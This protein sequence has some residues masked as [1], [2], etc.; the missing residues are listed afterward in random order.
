MSTLDIKNNDFMQGNYV[1]A[2][3]T[4]APDAVIIN[5]GSMSATRNGYVVLSGDYVENDGRIQAQTGRV[6]LA[7]GANATLTF[8]SHNLISYT[9][10]GATLARLAGAVNAGDIVATGGTVVM[11][12]DV[13]NA[14][15][16]TAVNNQGFIAAKSIKDHG[17]T[18]VLEATGGELINSGTLFANAAAGT[19]NMGGGTIILRGDDHT[20]L[21]STSRIDAAGDGTGAGG[22]IELS[23]HTLGVKGAA[24]AGKGGHLLIDPS[25]INITSGSTNGAGTGPTNSVGIGFIKNALN[26]N[27]NVT[28]VASNSIHNVTSGKTLTATG[29]GNLDFETGTVTC[30]TG[31]CVGGTPTITQ[32]TGTIDLRGLT[33]NIAGN[34]TAH[35]GFGSGNNGTVKLSDV[36]AKGIA[37]TG[38]FIN[39]G[40][41]H[42]TGTPGINLHAVGSSDDGGSLAA[43]SLTADTGAVSI[44]QVG[45]RTGI[46]VGAITANQGVFIS[47]GSGNQLLNVIIGGNVTGKS[48]TIRANGGN[49]D[50]IGNV[51]ATNGSVS[52]SARTSGS[53]SGGN[54]D[55]TGTITAVGARGGVFLNAFGGGSNATGSGGGNITVGGAIAAGGSVGISASYKQSGHAFKVQTSGITAGNTGPHG[56]INIIMHGPNPQMQVGALLA[57]GAVSAACSGEC[58]PPQRAGDVVLAIHPT[59]SGAGSI[60]VASAKSS[61]GNISIDAS[62]GYG[63]APITATGTLNAVAGNV[64]VAGSNLNL[65]NINAGGSVNLHA[66]QVGSSPEIIVAGNITAGG[67]VSVTESSSFD[68]NAITLGNV[69][70]GSVQINGINITTGN[71]ITTV[72]GVALYRP[73]HRTSGSVNINGSVN[74]KGAFLVNAAHASNNAHDNITITGNVTAAKDHLDASGAQGGGNITTKSLHANGTG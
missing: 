35:A 66:N 65:K 12:G 32:Q 16:A 57:Q 24:T 36:T 23:G 59:V 70:A 19:S 18:I 53:R 41:L 37:I 50:V 56:G 31:I 3:G 72:G 13:A 9:V 15:T 61:H 45:G 42:A 47:D 2:K 49:I 74:A 69:T 4:D 26:S 20:Q 30:P 40:N 34:F 54:I 6:Y 21:T 62:S 29:A 68:G 7:A 64:T 39:V 67:E 73:R 44:V 38:E 17:G 10:D 22:F 5:Q 43:G 51:K 71:L 27:N 1:F 14:L 25:L 28:I 63:F 46:S 52:M 48:V 8:D 60:K 58:G 33:I 11:T 55:V